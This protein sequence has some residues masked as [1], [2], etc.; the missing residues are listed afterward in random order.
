MRRGGGGGRAGSPGG[1]EG[2]LVGYIAVGLWVLQV[3]GCAD[4]CGWMGGG[5]GRRRPGSGLS[6]SASLEAAAT[7]G[8]VG[9][10]A[11]SNHNPRTLIHCDQR[12]LTR[13]LT[14]PPFFAHVQLEGRGVLDA[15]RQMLQAEGP[16][17]FF[18]SYR[19]TLVMNVPF[20]AMHFSVYETAKKIICHDGK[21]GTQSPD[22]TSK[23]GAVPRGWVEWAGRGARYTLRHL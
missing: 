16:G 14:C 6:L 13:H 3:A 20:T 22:M 7:A 5:A 9:T 23:K 8:G 11:L 2:W 17:S 1:A 15:A 12:C 18:R 10:A 19:T 21:E 4:G